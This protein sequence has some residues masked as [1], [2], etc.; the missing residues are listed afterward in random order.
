MLLGAEEQMPEGPW[1]QP[2]LLESQR[3]RDVLHLFWLVYDRG[4]DGGE[5]VPV[6]DIERGRNESC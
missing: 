2:P 6:V 1:S 5:G 3:V 4:G